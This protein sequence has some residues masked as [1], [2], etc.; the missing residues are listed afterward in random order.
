M[1]NDVV[2]EKERLLKA[3][4]QKKNCEL[5]PVEDLLSFLGGRD[6]LN[7]FWDRISSLS[8]VAFLLLDHGE[9]YRD[10]GT[11]EE[12]IVAHVYSDVL[13]TNLSSGALREFCRNFGLRY[14]IKTPGI[15]I[16]GSDD[17]PMLIYRKLRPFRK[18][19]MISGDRPNGGQILIQRRSKRHR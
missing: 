5:L 19:G 13:D 3:W 14:E 2:E 6:R 11:G 9:L 15:H 1:D 4:C 12:F 8:T 17:P 18:S 10:L 16:P 7:R